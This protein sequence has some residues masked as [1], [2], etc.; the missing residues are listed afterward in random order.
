MPEIQ[1]YSFSK[2]I[3]A[4]KTPLIFIIVLSHVNNIYS[5]VIIFRN[6][7]TVIT[8]AIIPAFFIIS[9]YFLLKGSSKFTFQL[10]Y[11][12]LQ[13]RFKTLFIPYIIWNL[14][15]ILLPIVLCLISSIY[16]LNI[17]KFYLF[18]KEQFYINNSFNPISLFWDKGNSYPANFPLWYIR[19]LIVVII[20]SP[21]LF[22]ILKKIK[23]FG[24][25]IFFLPT[26]F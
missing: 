26:M 13:S 17:E 1:K 5:D 10:Y 3:S 11:K 8:K 6:I 24:L 19:D 14:F 16:E 25:F 23:I 4:L 20:I 21:L 18:L 12:K 9:G 2:S 7:V 15:P 22:F